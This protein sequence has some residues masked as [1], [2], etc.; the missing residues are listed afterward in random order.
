PGDR[1]R[2]EQYLDSVRDIESRIGLAEKR[3]TDLALSLP[4]RPVDTPSD[5]ED[6]VKVMF[7]LQTLAFQGDITRVQT[8]LL[9]REQS[10]RA[11]PQLGVSAAHHTISHHGGDREKIAQKAKVDAFHV[12]LLTYYIEKLKH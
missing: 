4:D 7:D 11:Y 9:G 10:A 8:F 12:K 5:F 6:H 3:T 2:I 1:Q